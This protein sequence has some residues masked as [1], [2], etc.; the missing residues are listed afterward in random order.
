LRGRGKGVGEFE[1]GAQIPKARLDKTISPEIVEK[2][3][4]RINHPC[5][6]CYML[7]DS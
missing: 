5:I 2:W 7:V 6:G 4:L 1:Y 3:N